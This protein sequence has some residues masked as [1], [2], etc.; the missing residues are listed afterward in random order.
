VTRVSFSV[1]ADL[2]S[3]TVDWRRRPDGM[4]DIDVAVRSPS[5]LP[6]FPE[7]F[8]IAFATW[9]SPLDEIEAADP[10][11]V[12]ANLE[13]VPRDRPDYIETVAKIRI[14]LE[15]QGLALAPSDWRA[16]ERDF[17]RHAPDLAILQAGDAAFATAQGEACRALADHVLERGMLPR[18]LSR[19]IL[20][21]RRP[22]EASLAAMALWPALVC[23]LRDHIAANP[24]LEARIEAVA[25]GLP[26]PDHDRVEQN[27]VS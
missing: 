13:G 4:G 20:I 19:E 11:R 25:S 3:A 18:G 5:A 12:R 27:Y 9:R 8:R 26:D 7:G 2:L 24:D 1:A 22:S 10:R 23:A 17:V 6:D 14:A 21:G 15:V 16:V